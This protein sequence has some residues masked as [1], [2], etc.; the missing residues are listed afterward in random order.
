[1]TK[2]MSMRYLAIEESSFSLRASLFRPLEI[3]SFAFY[4]LKTQEGLLFF[5]F[6]VLFV[7][8]APIFVHGL[9]SVAVF[10]HSGLFFRPRSRALFSWPKPWIQP[11]FLVDFEDV[12]VFWL[13]RHCIKM[14]TSF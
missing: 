1:M 3:L 4:T 5:G 9:S 13:I 10:I 12:Y 6:M 14:H 11:T 8:K 7:F 2:R